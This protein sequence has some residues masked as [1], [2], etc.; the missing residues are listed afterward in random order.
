MLLLFHT[1]VVGH[2]VEALTVMHGRV[3]RAD[4][5]TRRIFTVLT[6]HTDE[7]DLDLLRHLSGLSRLSREVAI[8]AHPVHLAATEHLLLTNNR[9]IVLTLTGDDTGRTAGAAVHINRH[10]PLLDANQLVVFAAIVAFPDTD[11]GRRL[12]EYRMLVG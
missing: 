11:V 3:D 10:A 7:G 4:T 9:N 8:Q 5:F 1:T 2:Y 12:V 6:K